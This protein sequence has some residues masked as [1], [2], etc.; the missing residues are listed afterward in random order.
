M[1]AEFTVWEPQWWAKH[2]AS[3]MLVNGRA[4]TD[5]LKRYWGVSMQARIERAHRLGTLSAQQRTGLYS[6][7]GQPVQLGTDLPARLGLA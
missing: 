1:S 5:R 4:P 7:T 3:V 2:D 6:P